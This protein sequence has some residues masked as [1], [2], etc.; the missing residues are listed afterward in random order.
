MHK[1]MK[2]L[3]IDDLNIGEEVAYCINSQRDKKR[4]A[5]DYKQNLSDFINRQMKRIM[6]SKMNSEVETLYI[7][8]YDQDKDRK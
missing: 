1:N 6:M 3:A 7:S 5:R 8:G 2:L 4:G